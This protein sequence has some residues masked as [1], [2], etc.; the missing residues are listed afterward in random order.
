[1]KSSK[2]T[3]ESVFFGADIFA[4]EVHRFGEEK[5]EET[6]LPKIKMGKET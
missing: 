5:E 6:I 4:A 2:E 3:R 1:M